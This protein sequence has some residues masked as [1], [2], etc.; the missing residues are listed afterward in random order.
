MLLDGLERLE[1]V[2]LLVLDILEQFIQQTLVS[3]RDHASVPE[4]LHGRKWNKEKNLGLRGEVKVDT[5]QEFGVSIYF[6][7]GFIKGKT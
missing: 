7:E 3:L 2:L 1:G 5:I 6:S 4:A